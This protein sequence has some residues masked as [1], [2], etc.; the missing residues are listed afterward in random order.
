MITSPSFSILVDTKVYNGEEIV[1]SDEVLFVENLIAK[2]REVE[3]KLENGEF[4]GDKG[5]PGP[6]GDK[7]DKGE[8]G[9]KGEQGE[10]GEPGEK[11]DKGDKGDKGET[12]EKGEQGEKGEPGEKGDKGDKG[13]K[14]EAGEKGEQGEQGIQGA[15]GVY[16]GSGEM[17]DGYNVQIDPNGNAVNL[18]TEEFVRE[19]IIQYTTE[20]TDYAINTA[21]S[22]T[23][24]QIGDINSVIEAV[25]TKLA[26]L[27]EVGG[28]SL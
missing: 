20:K 12:G 3:Y 13:D 1:S 25:N 4:K 27:V 23:D 21:K 16:I 8:T 7:G 9:D 5:D 6:K 26:T 14:G 17:P 2:T 24:K 18:A 15:S 22:Y 28:D 11:G 19:E 10:K